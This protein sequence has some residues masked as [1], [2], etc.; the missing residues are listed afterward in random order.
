[1]GIISS[2]KIVNEIALNTFKESLKSRFFALF[3][4]FAFIML[5]ASA[6]GSML[7]ISH[8][9]RV[10]ADISLLL[11]EIMCLVYALFHVSSA[12]TREIQ[13]KTIYLILSRPVPRHIC[14]AGKELGVMLTTAFI[15]LITSIMAICVIKTRGLD[16][17]SFFF[18]AAAGAFLKTAIITAF[19][20][21]F[22]FVSTSDTTAFVMSGLLYVLGHITSE[23][24]PLMEKA[25]GAKYLILKACSIIFP[26]LNLYSLRETAEAGFPL[27]IGALAAALIW[28]AAA[29]AI[30]A[31]LFS[32]KEF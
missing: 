3:A 2:I 4:I 6:L 1:M 27:S 12:L 24:G 26:N 9:E 20:F 22:S 25:S 16:V 18:A 17:P 30:S 10:L 29:Y 23:L 14:L 7:S 19:A 21:L 11:I 28:I 8:E 15:A 32:K 13:E 31:W 5:Y